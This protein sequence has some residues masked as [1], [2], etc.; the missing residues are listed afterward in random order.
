MD[1]SVEMETWL[2]QAA[3]RLVDELDPEQIM[4]FG[5]FARGTPSRKSDV[6]L[7]VIWQTKLS[8]V[9][10]IGRVLR[11]LGDAPRPVEAVVYTPDEFRRNRSL[12]FVRS[13]LQEGRTLYRK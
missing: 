9:D 13:I 12:P 4:I 6:D 5:S 1:T 2:E 11:V 3:E 8:P 7:F 10:R